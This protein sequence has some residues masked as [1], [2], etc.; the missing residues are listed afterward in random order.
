MGEYLKFR[1]IES[2]VK[3]I[4]ASNCFRRMFQ[5]RRT[6]LLWLLLSTM[7]LFPDLAIADIPQVGPFLFP[8]QLDAGMR[9]SVQCAVMS[10][11]P[12]FEF[13]WLK[14]DQKLTEVR[15]VSVR[16][17]DDFTSNLVIAKVEADS[18]GNYTCRVSNSA[19][20]DEK[21]ALLSV[22][23]GPK[24]GPFHFSGELDVGMRATVV[25]SVMTGEP[26]FEFT[27]FKDDQ[28]LVDTHRVSLGKFD[29]FTYNLV[30]S[31]VEADSNGNY[32]CKVSNSAGFDQKS[33]ILS[34][35]DVPKI[36]PFNFP[37]DLDVGMRASVQCAVMTG[38][39]PF[40]F[41]WFKDGHKLVDPHGISIGNFGDFTSNLV[42]SKVDANSNGN[43]TCKVSNSAGFDERSAVLS[44]KGT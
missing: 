29:D 4:T 10:G 7:L 36:G 11:D 23:D 40:Q 28:K 37:G 39:P 43:Y 22:K 44:V 14:D 27:W 30:I 17:F 12:P 19:G 16:K 6:I 31:K 18:N 34:V 35:K 41:S 21:S 38:D 33:A 2:G 15:G 26:P 5:S 32:S 13:T 3:S 42:I 25:C 8:K 20:F 1:S 9:A 24:I